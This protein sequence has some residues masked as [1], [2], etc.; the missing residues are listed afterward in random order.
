VPEALNNVLLRF[1][2]AANVFYDATPDLIRD[3]ERA[4]VAVKKQR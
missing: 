1:S 3:L 4:L 2:M